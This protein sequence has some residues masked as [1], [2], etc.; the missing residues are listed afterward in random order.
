MCRGIAVLA[1]ALCAMRAAPAGAAELT[2]DVVCQ[3]AGHGCSYVTRCPLAGTG[4]AAGEGDRLI[5]IEHAS[6]GSRA[7]VLVGD[8]HPNALALIAPDCELADRMP[9]YPRALPGPW[10]SFELPRAARFR[11]GRIELRLLGRR[12]PFAA[13]TLSGTAHVR[14]RVP[15]RIV[16]LRR[17]PQPVQV[18]IRGPSERAW[19]IDLASRTGPARRANAIG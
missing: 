1:A 19:V 13:S 3:H 6:G 16:R 5:G 18:R 4:G 14:L 7:D 17:E 12:Q 11:G 15:R 8:A 9:A 2:S 10:L